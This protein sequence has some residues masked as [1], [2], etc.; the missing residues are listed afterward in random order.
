MKQN[1]LWKSV[2][3]VAVLLVFVYGIFGIPSS[4]TGQGLAS[5][6]LQRINLGLDLKGGTHLILQVQVNDAVNVDAQQ[7]IERLKSA[8]RTRNIAFADI[9]QSDPASNPDHIVVKGVSADHS[10][11]LRDIVSTDLTEYN[12][13]SGA[14]DTYTVSMKP[15]NLAQLKNRAVQQ[16]IETIRNR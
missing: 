16:A 3:I 12:L 11:D 14:Q 13:A 10:S 1:L 5:A 15:S 8:L 2:F 4:F 6:I 7:A 9:S